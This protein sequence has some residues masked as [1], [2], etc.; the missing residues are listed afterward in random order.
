MILIEKVL[1][2]KKVHFLG[3]VPPDILA[4]VAE[5][6]QEESIHED[7]LI[8]EKGSEAETTYVIIE[9]SVQE[10]NGKKSLRTLVA[11]ECFGLLSLLDEG[12][13]SASAKAVTDCKLLRVEQAVFRQIL[14]KHPKAM[15]ALLSVLSKRIRGQIA[16]S[17]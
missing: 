6:A 7:E 8:F 10:Y 14:L 15:S 13:R 17:K 2:L 1:L 4:W 9:G 12:T 16:L 3:S 11:G 5:S